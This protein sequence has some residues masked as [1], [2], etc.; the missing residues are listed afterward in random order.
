[1]QPP[2]FSPPAGP[3]PKRPLAAWQ[4]GCLSAFLTVAV[5]AAIGVVAVV[6]NPGNEFE[7]GQ[8]LGEGAARLAMIVGVVTGLVVHARRKRAKP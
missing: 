7:R 4:W 2:I 8:Q 5:V 1:M 3:P 6:L